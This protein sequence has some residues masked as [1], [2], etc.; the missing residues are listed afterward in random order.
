M[1]KNLECF[2][3]GEELKYKRDYAETEQPN[4]YSSFR[5]TVRLDLQTGW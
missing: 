3:S 2:S 4:M 5:C 1:G